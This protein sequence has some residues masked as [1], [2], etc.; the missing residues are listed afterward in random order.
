MVCLG[1]IRQNTLYKGDRDKDKDNNNNN[2]LI[3]FIFIIS[4]KPVSEMNWCP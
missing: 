1:D 4:N 3:R 2:I